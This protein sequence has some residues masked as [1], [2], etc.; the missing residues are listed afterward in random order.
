MSDNYED[1]DIRLILNLS[2]LYVS[3]HLQYEKW[4]G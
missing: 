4:E 3:S 1:P 2:H